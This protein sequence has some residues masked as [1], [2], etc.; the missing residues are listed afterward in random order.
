MKQKNL[1]IMLLLSLIMSNA[2]ISCKKD[3]T[4]PKPVCRVTGIIAGITATSFT[5]TADGKLSSQT[6]AAGT[7]KYRY[8]GNAII[9]TSTTG[10]VVNSITTVSLN[11]NGLAA[12]VLV[13]DSVGV[14]LANRSIEYNGT[15]I[16]KSIETT[17]AGD[18]PNTVKYTWS[19][20]NL[21]SI[22]F[23]TS[24]QRLTYST[25]RKSQTGDL[26]DIGNLVQGYV[27]QRSKNLVI[28]QDFNGNISNY[29]YIFDQDGK[30]TGFN[31][32]FSGAA[33]SFNYQYDCN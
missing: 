17:A 15:E 6:D 18:P 19:G 25:T 7:K 13:T 29:N 26:E 24:I 9:I 30:I 33:I 11:G 3:K 5:Y 22:D 20:G 27:T 8:V 12:N 28:S 21:V 31:T 16:S 1:P 10:N 4:D 32:I 2:L 23:G 14:F